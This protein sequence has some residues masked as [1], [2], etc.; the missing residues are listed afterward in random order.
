M[1]LEVRKV[2]GDR[3]ARAQVARP[4]GALLCASP[5][6]VLGLEKLK[7]QTQPVIAMGWAEDTAGGTERPGDRHAPPS[8]VSLNTSC[9]LGAPGLCTPWKAHPVCPCE[10]LLFLQFW[11]QVSLLPGSPP[12]FTGPVSPAW[13]PW[14][15]LLMRLHPCCERLTWVLL[16][17][18]G[19]LGTQ[20]GNEPT[21]G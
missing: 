15:D 17:L 8:P 16:C 20:R 6:K 18:K 4:G 21:C 13:G 5:C 11:T 12:R 3:W 10:L 9:F 14:E 2:G 1:V 19:E 7:S